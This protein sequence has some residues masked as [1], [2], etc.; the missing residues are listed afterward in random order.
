MTFPG[1]VRAPP[2]ITRCAAA[3]KEGACCMAAAIVVDGPVGMITRSSPCSCT[4]SMRN[5]AAGWDCAWVVAGGR[6]TSPTPLWPWIKEEISLGRN[7][8]GL[9]PA[10]TGISSW[11][12]SSRRA[13][14]LRTAKGTVTLPYVQVTP[15]RSRSGWAMAYASAR[16]SS[17]PVSRS[18]IAFIYF[19]RRK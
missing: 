4:A 6:R 7:P 15:I 3:A 11:P 9:G 2:I 13:S 17:M 8:S 19:S 12:S 10:K 1:T 18:R 5:S 14:V 16:A